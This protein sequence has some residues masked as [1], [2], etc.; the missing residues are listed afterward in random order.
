VKPARAATDEAKPGAVSD[1]KENR[2]TAHYD[3][4]I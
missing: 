4:G 2:P 3:V 1:P